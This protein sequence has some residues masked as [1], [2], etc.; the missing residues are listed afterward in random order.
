[1]QDYYSVESW[2]NFIRMKIAPIGDYGQSI[3]DFWKF[4][5]FKF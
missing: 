3:I 1:M 2:H 5:L 4:E